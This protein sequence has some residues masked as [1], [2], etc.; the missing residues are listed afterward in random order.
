MA[1]KII[2]SVMC[3]GVL[4]TGCTLAARPKLPTA[5]LLTPAVEPTTLPTSDSLPLRPPDAAAG[6]A[7]FDQKCA[8]CHG[9]GGKGDGPRAA[10]ITAQGQVVANLV[11]DARRRAAKP[12]DW[13]DVITSGRIQNLMPPFGNSLDAQ[14]I[15]D[16]EAYVWSLATPTQTLSAGSALYA[17]QCATCHGAA[18]T[19]GATVS[20]TPVPTLSDARFLASHSLLDIASGMT[21]GQ[22][23]SKLSLSEADR[24]RIAEV[25]RAFGYH[26]A[27][28]AQSRQT[29]ASGDGAIQLRVG[30]ATPGSNV[31]A[32]LPATLRAY[33]AT[34]E[35]LSRTAQTDS[36][37]LVTFT[38]LPTETNYFY[39]AE[40]AYQGG[41]FFA[42][43]VQFALTGT[44]VLTADVA[45]YETTT[46]PG[47]VSIGA[48][49]LFVQS[50]NEGTATMVE[51][52]QFDNA[53]DHAFVGDTK[54][55]HTL[56]LSL[57]KD[58]QNLRFDGLGLGKRFFQ[59][60]DAI[61]DTDV[62]VSGQNAQRVTMLY[63][64]P[65]HN[66]GSFERQ[67]FYP[68]KA[69]DVIVP[70]TSG[71]GTPLAVKGLT[72][73]GKQQMNDGT[74]VLLYSGT[75]AQA[76]DS[77]KFE[78]TGQPLGAAQPGSDNRSLGLGLIA[79]GV[80]AGLAYFTLRR[81]HDMRV[82]NE[83]PAQRREALLGEI[84]MLDNDF[85][86]GKLKERD[87]ERRRAQL[88]ADVRDLWDV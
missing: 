29:Q 19:T 34:S 35:V 36:T 3:L 30:N 80:A 13:H 7:I 25:V 79:L 1:K 63:E 40:V 33:D 70:E 24:L 5:N 14:Q 4:L 54:T 57:P 12:G 17:A 53:S 21:R 55:H 65:Y 83:N 88:K 69:W 75:P 31:L 46:D 16:V 78:L 6:A 59:D 71:S 56:K 27:D 76:G 74:S 52:Y 48:I 15:W 23:H 38:R 81:V 26:Y 44:A 8:A 28:P 37:G 45:V 84:A 42:S 66:G 51:F 72:D 32:G 18:G 62:V 11:E 87:Y 47:A 58:A 64:V 67:T 22:A 85:E 77:L 49:H 82:A 61:Y 50:I 9:S 43:P 39:Q 10:Q 2:L 60:G 20:K 73:K 68:V 41:T 86:A